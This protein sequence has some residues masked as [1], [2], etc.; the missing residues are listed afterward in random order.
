MPLITPAAV[1]PGRTAMW[2][3]T[4]R[5]DG[6]AY[7]A[8]L[9]KCSST[10][11]WPRLCRISFT[12]NNENVMSELFRRKQETIDFF[13]GF[14]ARIREAR[15][16]RDFTEREAADAIGITVRR[17]CRFES[18]LP[19]AATT[20]PWRRLQCGSTSTLRDSSAALVL[21]HRGVCYSESCR[22]VMSERLHVRV[23]EFESHVRHGRDARSDTASG[24]V[25]V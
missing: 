22:H 23:V 7:I 11:T 6:I 1:I 19:F 5:Q 10:K 21:V 25:L 14:G 16:A 20:A 17:L 18:G 9:G 13:Q 12:R 3:K 8:Y 2:M 24:L 4:R 15:L